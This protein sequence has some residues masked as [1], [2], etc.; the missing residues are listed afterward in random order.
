[1][2]KNTTPL[3]RRFYVYLIIFLCA[4]I[5]IGIKSTQKM[6]FNA[7]NSPMCKE[8]NIVLIVIDP[9]RADAL[10]C[11][12]YIANTTPNICKF[13]EN[14]T[15]YTNTFSQS[16]WTLPSIMSLFSSQYPSQHGMFTPLVDVLAATTTTLPMT[17]KAAG[18]NTTFIGPVDDPT[19]HIPLDKGVGRGFDSIFPYTSL[20]DAAIILQNKLKESSTTHKPSFVFI[21]S[22]DLRNNSTKQAPTQFP[23]DPNY[24]YGFVDTY[25]QTIPLHTQDTAGNITSYK[26][27]YDERLRQLDLQFPQLLQSIS[28]SNNQVNT[29]IAITSDHGEEFGEHGQSTHGLNL[30]KTVTHVPFILSIPKQTPKRIDNLVQSIDIFPTLINAIGI[31]LPSSVKGINVLSPR[32]ST[33]NFSIS[34]LEPEKHL[35]AI[36]NHTWAYYFNP[37]NETTK[38]KGELYNTLIDPSETHPILS[39]DPMV[40]DELIH[41]Y[42]RIS[43]K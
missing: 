14:N 13:A 15:L 5:F 37:D 3:H 1:M 11:Y 12:G 4:L 29:M 32:A 34:Q 42:E 18:Y 39:P 7:R 19:H 41:T 9:L 33:N 27:I 21:H 30:Y 6:T 40:I 8:C 24:R 28:D 17:L 26:R 35:V 20:S 16:S 23:L 43:T 10:P 2:T 36:R 38:R 31:P 25:L 22:F